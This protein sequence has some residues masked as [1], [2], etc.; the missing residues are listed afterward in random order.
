MTEAFEKL[1]SL[2][3][4]PM[5]VVTT[6]VDDEWAG[7]LVGFTS[8]VSIRP[9]RFLVG[10]SKRNHTFR[11]AERDALRHE[12][13]DH[14][15]EEGQDQVREQDGKHGRHHRVERL[16]ERVLA[17]G[18]DT[19]RRER[20]AELHRRDELR[21]V[22][23]DL[24]NRPRALIA[25][26]VEL[27]DARAPRRDQGVFG[28]DEEAV[29]QHEQPDADQL[30]SECQRPTPGAL[31]LEG[32]SSTSEIGSIGDGPVVLDAPRPAKHDEPLEMGQ[33]F[34]DG[35]AALDRRELVPEQ[36]VRDVVA[37]PR[38]GPERRF[39]PVESLLVVRGD[40]GAAR[41]R[42]VHVLAM[43]PVGD[44]RREPGDKLQRVQVV[45]QR[46][47][48]ALRVE[49]D[50]RSDRRAPRLVPGRDAGLAG[51]RA[52]LAR[53]REHSDP[54]AVVGMASNS[55]LQQRGVADHQYGH[56]LVGARR[57]IRGRHRACASFTE[58]KKAP[59]GQVTP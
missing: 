4:Y 38:H 52:I 53:G 27:D 56:R 36:I 16:R 13:A 30:E 59:D 41:Y 19:Q 28:R 45:A 42:I 23:R 43:S 2:L 24:Q 37:R 31:V 40:C 14:D 12:L 26:M 34:G 18:A 46:V 8:Q 9:P 55:T 54:P 39:G 11:V 10:L 17:E 51:P 20:D 47:G 3:D 5:F 49:P 21:R 29:E 58:P 50:R 33:R 35:K 22:A 25:L 57:R 48:P 7:C 44:A 15:M 6:R 32:R 1:V